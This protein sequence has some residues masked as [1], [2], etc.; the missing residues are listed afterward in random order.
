MMRQKPDRMNPRH[1][2]RPRSEEWP[3]SHMST[4]GPAIPSAALSPPPVPSH[5]FAMPN[6]RVTMMLPTHL[7][8]R[9]R[10][11]IY[12]TERR[13]MARVVA[14]ALHD[15]VAEMEEAN[16]GPFPLR[17]TPLKRGRPRGAANAARKPSIGQAS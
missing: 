10:N 12:W 16:G 1:T 8:E 2:G 3:P 9:L 11:A 15:A 4:D 7:V 5:G 6:Q 17:L 13:T 14:D